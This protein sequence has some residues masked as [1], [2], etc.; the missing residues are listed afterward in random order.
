MLV[1][2]D[3]GIFF[4]FFTSTD[5]D[6]NFHSTN[7]FSRLA[8]PEGE[9]WKPLSQFPQRLQHDP[10]NRASKSVN[11]PLVN[12]QIL[13]PN[14]SRRKKR[15]LNDSSINTDT[16]SV[17][18]KPCSLNA[19][20]P[21]LGCF[22]D[23]SSPLS[24][25]CSAS[26]FGSSHFPVNENTQARSSKIKE[27]LSSRLHV[28][29]DKCGPSEDQAGEVEAVV[30]SQKSKNHLIN[31]SH[32]FEYEV[33]DILCLNP[34]KEE[35]NKEA[36]NDLRVLEEDK[37][38]SSVHPTENEEHNAESPPEPQCKERASV[39]VQHLSFLNKNSTS[40]RQSQLEPIK[41][42]VEYLEGEDDVLIIG[43]PIFESSVCQPSA[44]EEQRSCLSEVL[45]E[46]ISACWSYTVDTSY[47]TTLPLQVQVSCFSC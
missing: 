43:E 5:M 8:L 18:K 31:I 44:A 29:H 38:Y 40:V 22:V 15:K 21:D 17:L 32:N 13:I 33:D 42:V 30:L 46:P 39:C 47:E 2:R 45:K 10:N 35:T 36:N 3:N 27:T 28:E 16:S 25:R 41:P 19:L 11:R 9:L 14:D 6:K 1:S 12:Y 23:F 34:L 20:S 7:M 26:L 24:G 37:G 4:F